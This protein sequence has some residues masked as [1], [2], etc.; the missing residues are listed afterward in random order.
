MV[1]EPVCDFSGVLRDIEI[2]HI[3]NKQRDQA[4]QVLPFVLQDIVQKDSLFLSFCF[5]VVDI[6]SILPHP[7]PLAGRGVFDFA[8]EKPPGRKH[9]GFL[10]NIC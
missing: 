6:P 9:R 2:G 8:V 7:V 4:E 3:H 5:H 10:P 1:L